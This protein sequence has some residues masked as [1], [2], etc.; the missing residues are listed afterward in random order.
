MPRSGALPLPKFDCDHL[1]ISER[2][3]WDFFG[4]GFSKRDYRL[5]KLT[6]SAS[7]MNSLRSFKLMSKSEAL[8]HN[9]RRSLHSKPEMKQHMDRREPNFLMPIPHSFGSDLQ[10][11]WLWSPLWNNGRDHELHAF[12]RVGRSLF[13]SNCCRLQKRGIYTRQP[14]RAATHDLIC[15][16]KFVPH[17][18]WNGLD[19][20]LDIHIFFLAVQRSC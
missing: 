10:N 5:R 2:H 14:Q 6:I 13:R 9:K 1:E 7:R 12:D 8:R 16:H 4:Y 15:L 19:R 3:T 11:F 20:F 17:H 18:E